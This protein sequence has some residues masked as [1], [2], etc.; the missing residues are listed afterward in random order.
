M[1][2][3]FSLGDDTAAWVTADEARALASV[4]AGTPFTVPPVLFAKLTDEDL[5]TY[6]ER[7]GGT[8]G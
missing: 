7:F 2:E 4:P 8:E 5:E 3:A 6:K 1:R